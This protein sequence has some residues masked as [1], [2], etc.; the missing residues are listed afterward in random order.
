M[1]IH[2]MEWHTDLVRGL[3]SS[4]VMCQMSSPL[5]SFFAGR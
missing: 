1:I 3:T 2:R 4:G 5:K